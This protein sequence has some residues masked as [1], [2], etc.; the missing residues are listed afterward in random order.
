MSRLQQDRQDH[1]VMLEELQQQFQD[2]KEEFDNP[3]R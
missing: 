2:L 1:E 3:K